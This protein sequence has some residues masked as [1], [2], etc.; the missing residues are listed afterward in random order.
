[1]KENSKTT[2][3]KSLIYSLIYL[4]T[5]CTIAVGGYFQF[6][7]RYYTGVLIDGS[8]MS[9]TLNKDFSTESETIDGKSYIREN[10]IN[11]GLINEH[12]EATKNINRYSIVT[13]Y[14][15]WESSD[16]TNYGDSYTHNQKA[17][18]GALYKIKRVYALPGDTFKIEEGVFSLKI[19]DEW[20]AQNTFD[21]ETN[22]GSFASF[23]VKE[24]NTSLRNVIEK[25]LGEKEYWV[26]GDNW[27]SS[28][29][30]YEHT[31]IYKENITGVLISILGKETHRRRVGFKDYELISRTY[32]KNPLYFYNQE[33]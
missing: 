12:K 1:M 14:Y 26:M 15:P 13:C 29:D 19:N 20:V 16:Y 18:K 30:C 4:L 2:F 6:Q 3:V 7:Q 8:S 24:D 27:V 25:T 21:S 9:P 33:R 11:F 10:N 28:V 32:Y 31:N 5:A 22:L 17:K 23:S